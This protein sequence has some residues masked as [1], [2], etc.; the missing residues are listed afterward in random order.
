[1]INLMPDDM[2][3]E[4][5]SARVNVVLARYIAVIFLAFVFLV[6]LLVGSY[7]VLTQ[8]KVAAQRV[9]DSNGTKAAVYDSTKTQVNAL[10][11]SLSQAKVILD[12][13]VLYSNVLMNIGQQMPPGTVLSSI[14]LTAASFTGT[15]VTLKA[16]AKTTDDVVALRAKFQSTPIFSNVNFDSVSQ[17]SGIDGY[18]VSVSMTLVVTKAATQ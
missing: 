15:P 14:T 3:K 6:L 9:I 7:F 18:P 1:M 4:I 10:S 12:Q 16:Y 17:S 11:G 8:T 2:K 5:S 13:E